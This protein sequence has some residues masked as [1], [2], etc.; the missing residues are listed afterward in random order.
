[1]LYVV[2]QLVLEMMDSII[3]VN[4]GRVRKLNTVCVT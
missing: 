2:S 3:A 1:V 4:F